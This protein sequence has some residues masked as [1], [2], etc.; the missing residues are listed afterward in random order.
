MTDAERQRKRRERQ[1]EDREAALAAGSIS[2]DPRLAKAFRENERLRQ[3]LRMFEGAAMAGKRLDLKLGDMLRQL[4]EATAAA[5][6]V[7]FNA[8][9]KI[10]KA[11]HPDYRPSDAEREEAFKAF[12]QIMGKTRR[13]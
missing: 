11:L 1:R 9:S 6:G 13:R 10:A 3:R 8:I 5:D 12:S 4:S 2:D 7:S